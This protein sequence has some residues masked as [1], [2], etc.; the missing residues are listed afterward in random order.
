MAHNKPWD[1]HASPAM[2]L[3]DISLFSGFAAALGI[4][5]EELV[6]RM[7]GMLSLLRPSMVSGSMEASMEANM[8]ASMPGG[9]SAAGG[10]TLSA[11]ASSR[12]C[13]S[14][15][16]P[17][18]GTSSATLLRHNRRPSVAGMDG[19]RL[20]IGG[21]GCGAPGARDLGRTGAAQRPVLAHLAAPRALQS[22]SGALRQAGCRMS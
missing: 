14:L 19:V 5:V 20:V 22:A 1:E 12:S 17:A 16:S 11:A 2:V 15:S 3:G 21:R 8:E 6:Q 10:S 7:E 13:S 18:V 4:G 9:G